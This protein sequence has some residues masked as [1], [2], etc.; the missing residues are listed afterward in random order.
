MMRSLYNLSLII[1]FLFGFELLLTKIGATEETVSDAYRDGIVCKGRIQP[2]MSLNGI[3]LNSTKH[4]QGVKYSVV[5]YDKGKQRTYDLLNFMA[6]DKLTNKRLLS[7]N[8][9]SAEILS[10]IKDPFIGEVVL[11]PVKNKTN[12]TIWVVTEVR[13]NGQAVRD[14]VLIRPFL[15]KWHGVW[16]NCLG[17]DFEISFLNGH[18]IVKYSGA[19]C[20]GINVISGQLSFNLLCGEKKWAF[21]IYMK[22]GADVFG[23]DVM[24]VASYNYRWFEGELYKRS[25]L[26]GDVVKEWDKIIDG[27]GRLVIMSGAE[28]VNKYID[29][30]VDGNRD[31][32][33]PNHFTFIDLKEGQHK[34]SWHIY[35]NIKNSVF[36]IKSGEIMFYELK[37]GRF[38]SVDEAM[39]NLINMHN[40]Y[41]LPLP[42][43]KQKPNANKDASLR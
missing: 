26:Y 16:S 23:N 24:K 5:V 1:V 2:K 22:P 42:F 18:P 10:V 35:P 12:K 3:P 30:D 36:T 31:L 4:W 6:D 43:N 29:F 38:M 9:Y 37:I 14:S 27:T 33:Y 34:I 32:I 8:K 15:G 17:D 19:D 21:D 20:S 13:D 11:V 25:L 40:S 28:K 7:F 41:L 39:V